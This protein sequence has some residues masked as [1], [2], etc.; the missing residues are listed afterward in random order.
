MAKDLL[1]T[2]HYNTLAQHI[3]PGLLISVKA[4]INN[5]YITTYPCLSTIDINSN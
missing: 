3:H 4:P 1:L 5:Y 2:K